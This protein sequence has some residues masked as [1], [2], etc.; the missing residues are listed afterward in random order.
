MDVSQRVTHRL[1]LS[2]KQ[3]REAIFLWR[4]S[5]MSARE[6]GERLGVCIDAINELLKREL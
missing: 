2:A 3:R 1:N 4:N 5:G 6:I